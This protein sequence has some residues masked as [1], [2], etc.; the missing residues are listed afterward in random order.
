MPELNKQYQL[1]QLAQLML[2]ATTLPTPTALT[3]VLLI[4]GEVPAHQLAAIYE[5]MIGLV[6][7]GGKTITIGEQV[8][9][10]Q[11]PAYFVIP[12]DIPAT[13]YV[14]QGPNGLPYLSVGLALNH[15]ILLD[16]LK[17]LPES[18]GQKQGSTALNA[19]TPSSEMLDAWLRLLQLLNTPQAI[20]AL[21][22]VYE[23]EIL[24]WVL[25]GPQGW[26]LRQ[27][28]SSGGKTTRIR[29]A[30]HWIRENYSAPL[31]IQSIANKSDLGVTTFHRQFKQ[32]TG[33]SPIQYQK[34]LRLLEA[35]KRLVFSHDSVSEAAYAVGYES[36]SQFNREYTRFFGAP[37]AR[38]AA[39]I[40][41]MQVQSKNNII[42]F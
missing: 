13:G 9:S 36:P 21:A 32:M 34:Q 5:P 11:A 40:R 15:Q 14:Q 27:I 24:Y 41:R 42:N 16:L 1:H 19:C 18:V 8:I 26:R 4:Q 12:T 22:P 23:R 33:L 30:I 17:D 37:P 39:S 38:D 10:A 20:P 7:Q 28:C 3:G 35:R 2:Q 31:N 25:I 6:I 29:Q